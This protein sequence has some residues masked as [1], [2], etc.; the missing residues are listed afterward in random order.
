MGKPLPVINL[1][2]PPFVNRKV[3]L[4]LFFALGGSEERPTNYEVE[5]KHAT[6]GKSFFEEISY[7]QIWCAKTG[8]G[9]NQLAT[10]GGGGKGKDGKSSSGFFC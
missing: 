3:E 9:I 6:R 10:A 1:S 8:R 2:L 4:D 5:Q 7:K